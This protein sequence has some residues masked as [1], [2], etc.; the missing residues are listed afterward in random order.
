MHACAIG[1]GVLIESFPFPNYSYSFPIGSGMYLRLNFDDEVSDKWIEFLVKKILLWGYDIGGRETAFFYSWRNQTEEH[2]RVYLVVILDRW[3]THRHILG[4]SYTSSL[5]YPLHCQESIDT[6]TPLCPV[7]VE[8]FSVPNE[9]TSTA[10]ADVSAVS[11]PRS[12]SQIWCLVCPFLGKW[13][14][15]GYSKTFEAECS[16]GPNF[17]V[18]LGLTELSC[19]KANRIDVM[20]DAEMTNKICT[21]CVAPSLSTALM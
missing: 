7:Q 2:K 19:P 15:D 17:A 9:G 6:A 8:P 3:H 12:L 13:L 16:L 14:G 4:L 10:P 11:Q 1:L 21:I 18:I 20:G 5:S